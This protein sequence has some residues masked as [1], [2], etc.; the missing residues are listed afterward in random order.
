LN[1]EQINILNIE[2]YK[3]ADS[4]CRVSDKHS[5]SCI[6]VDNKL[7]IRDI[8]RIKDLGRDKEFKATELVDLRIVLIC[9]YRSPQSDVNTF[10]EKLEVLINMVQKRGKY[11]V[12]CGDWNIDLLL[13]NSHQQA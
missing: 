8:N 3:L 5:G 11:L 13:E 9:I 7:L 10:L 6:F 4:F 1:D 12:L 2:H